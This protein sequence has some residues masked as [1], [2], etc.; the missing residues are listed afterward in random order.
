MIL[1]ILFI[2]SIVTRRIAGDLL[3][4]FYGHN[5]MLNMADSAVLNDSAQY[6]NFN[7]A[8]LDLDAFILHKYNL[9]LLYD[10]IRLKWNIDS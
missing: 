3:R 6:V 2:I 4:R 10:G 8:N 7:V 5:C 1:P 9:N